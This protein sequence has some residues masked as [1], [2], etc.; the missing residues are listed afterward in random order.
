MIFIRK[1]EISDHKDIAEICR[2]GLGYNC[3]DEL[4]KERL[5]ELDNSREAVFAA[6]DGEE[7]VGFVHAEKYCLLY[8]EMM[9][10]ILGLAVKSS[11]RRMGIG[12]LLMQ[13]V[14][15]YAADTGAVGIRLNS[16]GSR[17]EAH[18]FY[19]KIGFDSE[20]MQIRFISQ[21]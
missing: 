6:C 7:T 21:L 9:I 20:K 10:N 2:D 16:G 3:S 18:E 14:R 19:R 11:H 8:S 12:R 15:K 17:K 1:A 13:E 4:V 5:S